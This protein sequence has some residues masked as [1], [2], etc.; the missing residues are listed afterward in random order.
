[1][2][3]TSIVVESVAVLRFRNNL[4]SQHKCLLD[5]LVQFVNSSLPG[6]EVRLRTNQ[7][8]LRF[9]VRCWR[10]FLHFVDQLCGFSGI[11]ASDAASYV[12]LSNITEGGILHFTGFCDG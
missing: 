5:E 7:I 6:S 2:P 11:L 9:F 3:Q 8:E 10:R 12:Q 1:M 4:T